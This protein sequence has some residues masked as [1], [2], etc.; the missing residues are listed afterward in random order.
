MIGGSGYAEASS[1]RT[2]ALDTAFSM[3]RDRA[4]FMD[5]IRAT[6]FQV[7]MGFGKVD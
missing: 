2:L 6:N 5:A 1:R 7:R 3:Q 4:S